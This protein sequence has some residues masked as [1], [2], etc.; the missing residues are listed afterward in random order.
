VVAFLGFAH[1]RVTRSSARLRYLA[2]SAFPI[3][4][5]HQPV[6]VVLGYGVVQLPLGIAAKFMLLLSGSVIVTLAIYHFGVRRFGPARYLAGMKQAAKRTGVTESL[7]P[8]AATVRRSFSVRR[9]L[10]TSIFTAALL[11]PSASRADDPTGVW[12][13]DGG[14]AQV[15][16]VHCDDALCGKVVWLRSPFDLSGCPLRDEK[17]PNPALRGRGVLGLEL[18]NGL[19]RLAGDAE[20]WEGGQIYDPGAGRTYRATL[21]MNGPDKL[22]LRGYVGIRLLGRTTSW[23]RVRE[24]MQCRE[25][26]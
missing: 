11:V 26:G 10:W 22:E 17:N 4:L 6:T 5:L 19:R 9:A 1:E 20:E 12:W 8:R 2:E 14:A 7:G 15:E 16:I 24:D 21:R 23:I 13:A 25:T 18:L 3:F